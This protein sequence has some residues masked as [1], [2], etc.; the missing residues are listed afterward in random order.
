[1]WVNSHALFP[2]KIR[3]IYQK[4]LIA[5]K[6]PVDD[7]YLNWAWAENIT[8]EL[9]ND[10]DKFFAS[11]HCYYIDYN[12]QKSFDQ[13]KSL[14][15][16]S[17]AKFRQFKMD[18]ATFDE[19][20]TLETHK[21]VTI[22][23]VKTEN[24]FKQWCEIFCEGYGAYSPRY[25]Y[26]IYYPVLRA[27]EFMGVI[28]FY[29]NTPVT[30]GQLSYSDDIAGIFAIATIPKYR[31]QG[32]AR[33]ISNHLIYLAKKAGCKIAVLNST[34]NADEMYSKLG[35]EPFLEEYIFIPEKYRSEA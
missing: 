5:Y 21:D 12:N 13:A 34:P 9:I 24:D 31:F 23:Q 25:I 15:L 10:I 7:V 29:N 2:D 3:Y 18:L 1:M 4:D 30:T 32:F 35:F 16:F 26:E 8:P 6:T 28:L 27:G 22:K 19:F 33:I 14:G 11:P 20:K 17:I